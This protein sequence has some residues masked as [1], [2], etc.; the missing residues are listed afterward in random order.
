MNAMHLPAPHAPP[1]D[2]VLLPITLPLDVF[3]RC[4][5][6]ADVVSIALLWPHWIT[7]WDALGDYDADP[8]DEDFAVVLATFRR[9]QRLGVQ[10]DAFY[11]H[12]L[13][14]LERTLLHTPA[15]SD[16]DGADELLDLE[17]SDEDRCVEDPETDWHGEFYHMPTIG[18]L[19]EG[20]LPRPP[21][22][23]QPKPRTFPPGLWRGSGLIEL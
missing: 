11:C 17:D 7:M 5:V 12:A 19:M 14:A 16:G 3:K 15:D 1:K 13:E 18:E 23:K 21:K 2:D 22:Y 9:L 20:V 6:G 4:G 8:T 10:F